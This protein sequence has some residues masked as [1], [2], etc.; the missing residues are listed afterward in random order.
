MKGYVKQRVVSAAKKKKRDTSE[1]ETK[2]Q[3][4][5]KMSKITSVCAAWY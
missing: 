3:V 5:S 1:R 4:L 2:K